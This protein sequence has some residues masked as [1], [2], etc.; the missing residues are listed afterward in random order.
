MALKKLIREK[1]RNDKVVKREND[2]LQR[3][4]ATNDRL[5]RAESEIEKL[6]GLLKQR[7]EF[8]KE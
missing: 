4:A 1:D 2:A 6:R 5:K 7:D 8:I 3:C